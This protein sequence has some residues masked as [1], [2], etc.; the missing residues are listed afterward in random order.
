M[1]ISGSSHP[2]C[3]LHIREQ[4]SIKKCIFREI[5][6]IT[7]QLAR[8]SK[9]N[10]VDFSVYI[11][12]IAKAEARSSMRSLALQSAAH[13]HLLFNKRFGSWRKEISACSLNAVNDLSYC[14]VKLVISAA[15]RLYCHYRSGKGLC[16][17]SFWCKLVE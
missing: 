4:S 6:A 17:L 15:K 2:C 10:L 14:R 9:E 8:L 11:S 1:Q 7:L 5:G 16:N 3:L 13:K 12:E